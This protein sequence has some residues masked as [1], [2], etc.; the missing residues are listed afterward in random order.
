[1]ARVTKEADVRRDELLDVALD[2]CVEVGFEAMSVE[3]VTSAAG[4]AKGTFYHYFASKQELLAQLVSRFGDQLFDHLESEMRAVDGDALTRLGALM[5]ISATWKLERLNAAMAY[6]PFLFK[7]EN[8]TLRYRLYTEWLER[9]RPL[10]L[11]IVTQGT[12]DGTFAVDDPGATTTVL[13]TLWIDGGNRMWESAIAAS[14]FADSMMAGG[15]AIL[16]AQERIL[17][18]PDGSL[19]LMAS[20]EP[21]ALDGVRA[22]LVEQGR[23]FIG[24]DSRSDRGRHT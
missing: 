16:A 2:L 19:D 9:L 23:G 4:V 6:L 17:R 11:E 1:M 7:E 8:Y 15:A 22:T 5:N 18:A 12:R 3:Q 10:V 13:L 24:P 14:D 20:I 21:G